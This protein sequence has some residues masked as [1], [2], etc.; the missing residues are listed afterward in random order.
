MYD[1]G[2]NELMEEYEE[3]KLYDLPLLGPAILKSQQDRDR[4]P[5]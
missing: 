1:D 3:R 4:S 2:L 5:S